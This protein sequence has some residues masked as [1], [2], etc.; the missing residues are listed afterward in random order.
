[1]FPTMQYAS[2]LFVFVILRHIYWLEIRCCA[3]LVIP[4]PFMIDL[5]QCKQPQHCTPCPDL[6][7][8]VL[9]SVCCYSFC[10]EM[11]APGGQ[12]LSVSTQHFALGGHLPAHLWMR[13]HRSLV[14]LTCSWNAEEQL[15]EFLVSPSSP[16]PALVEKVSSEVPEEPWP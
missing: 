7:L 6:A 1:M 12:G 15:R 4:V 3:Q 14:R 8:S 13:W 11:I 9:P 2:E 5:M 16:M 10:S